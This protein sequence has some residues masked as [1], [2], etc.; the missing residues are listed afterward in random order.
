MKQFNASALTDSISRKVFEENIPVLGVC[1]GCQMLM[2]KSE[3]GNEAGLGWIKGTVI[4]F[5]KENLPS[6]HKIP[7]MGWTDVHPRNG[8]TLYH[9]LIEPR[10]YFVHSY[11]VLTDAANITA[12]ATY[13]YDFTASIGSGNIQGVQFHPEK[14]HKFGMKLYSN[15]IKGF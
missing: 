12:T 1:V 8:A 2:E 15:F 13:G 4:K 11:H 5:K 3:E 6:D 7:H 10:F 14:S 9:E